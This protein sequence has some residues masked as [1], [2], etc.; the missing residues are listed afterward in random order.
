MA[1]TIITQFQDHPD[2]WSRVDAIL[3]KSP[4]LQAKVGFFVF[5]ATVIICYGLWCL[6]HRAASTRKNDSKSL[7]DFAS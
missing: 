5:V 3:A 7:E 2:A 6:V 1:Q 4:S